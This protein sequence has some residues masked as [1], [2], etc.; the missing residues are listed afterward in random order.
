[1][2]LEDYS[3][4]AKPVVDE[5][6]ERLLKA[7]Q[8]IRERGWCQGIAEM[9]SGEVCA[10]GAILQTGRYDTVGIDAYVRLSDFVATLDHKCLPES[11]G[12]NFVARWNDH[13]SRTKAEVIA[14]LEAA[15]R[16]P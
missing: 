9:R 15:A 7:A 4:P 11:A 6:G 8:I 14:A 10:F 12:T 3:Q 13:P 1:M 16:L 2:F 5:I